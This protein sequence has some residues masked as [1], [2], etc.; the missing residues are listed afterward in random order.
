[1]RKDSFYYAPSIKV[2]QKTSLFSKTK[3]E[4]LDDILNHFTP[5]TLPKKS[6]ISFSEIEQFFFVVIKG[7]VKISQ[8]CI[9]T[10]REYIAEVLSEGDIFDTIG[11]LYSKDEDMLVETIDV[12][13]LLKT[14]IQKARELLYTHP[15]FNKNVFSCFGQKM[16]ALNIF[17]KELIFYD[18]ATRLARLILRYYQEKRLDIID[19]LSMDTLAKMIGSCRTVVNLHIIEFKKEGIISTKDAKLCVVDEEKLYEKAMMQREEME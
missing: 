19:D 7:R 6:T 9:E 10:G 15:I 1:M 4:D 12:T 2:L 17:A 14:P 16:Y 5:M 8:F 13:W 18:T 3:P 11:L